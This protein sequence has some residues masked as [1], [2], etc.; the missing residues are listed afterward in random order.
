MT[1]DLITL[2]LGFSFSKVL[3]AVPMAFKAMELYRNIEHRI[4]R[5][6]LKAVVMLYTS[7]ALPKTITQLFLRI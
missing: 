6:C 5:H 3:P 4:A 1:I 7:R 2:L